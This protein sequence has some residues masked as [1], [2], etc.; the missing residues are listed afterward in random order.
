MEI[1]LSSPSAELAVGIHDVVYF[2][3]VFAHIVVLYCGFRLGSF[4]FES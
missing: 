3:W 2:F 4:I 1:N